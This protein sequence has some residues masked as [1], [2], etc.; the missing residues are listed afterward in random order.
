MRRRRRAKLQKTR[1]D[2]FDT[3]AGLP[4]QT[5]GA[6]ATVMV[7]MGFISCGLAISRGMPW[8]V[9][10]GVLI[11]AGVMLGMASLGRY[12][13]VMRGERLLRRQAART[14]LEALSWKEFE[15]LVAQIY[16]EQGFDARERGREGADGGV[17]IEMWKGRSFALVQCKHWKSAR[18]GVSMAREMYGLMYA[19]GANEVKIVTTGGFTREAT[20]FA[21]GKPIDLVDGAALKVALRRIDAGRKRQR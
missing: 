14:R 5:S 6:C 20:E 11:W 12:Y 7:G 19:H 2:W 18:V 10:A 3:A 9:S 1:R 21:K 17:D 4:W 8:L 16:R 15:I 13:T